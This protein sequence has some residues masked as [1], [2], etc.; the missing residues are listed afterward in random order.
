MR[1]WVTRG[2]H[3][4]HTCAEFAGKYPLGL[5]WELDKSSSGVSPIVGFGISSVEH[6]VYNTIHCES[7]LAFGN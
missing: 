1:T 4:V 7:V 3:G 2:R 6:L 5:R